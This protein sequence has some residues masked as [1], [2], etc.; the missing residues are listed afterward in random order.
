MDSQSASPD[1]SNVAAWSPEPK[2]N[3]VVGP[4]EMYEP[5]PRE[6]L[7]RNECIAFSPVD[8]KN[9]QFLLHPMPYPG[10]LGSS[11]AGTVEKVGRD[12]THFQPGD[13]VACNRASY[14]S[15]NLRFGAFQ[16]YAL[17][18]VDESS[19]LDP[20]TPIQAA[21]AVIVNLSVSV[22][23]L[24][25]YLKLSRPPLSGKAPSQGKKV[26]VYGGSS[27]CGGYGV[28][29]ASDAGYIV[30]TTSSPKHREFV[31][32]LGAAKIIDHTQSADKVVAELEANGPYEA[33]YDS[34]GLPAV[35]NILSGYLAER[36]GKY[37]TLLPLLGPENPVPSNVV[38]T[39]GAW[40][41]TLL[42][43]ANRDLG[44]WYYE[45]YVPQGLLS[46]AITPTR[47]IEVKGGL[48]KVQEAINMMGP[49]GVSGQ[50]LVLNPQE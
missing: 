10:I 7:V 38:R 28:K 41:A 13:K 34:I 9:Q 4:A 5:G 2:A 48:E 1:K 42:E 12:V 3:L 24:S 19:K 40:S 30:V 45:Q 35:T 33:I 27:S 17:A 15:G 29:Y 16:K 36:G 22:A 46:G 47:Q 26:L 31:S 20:Q 11:F 23:A 37:C 39:F 49:A 6:M 32:S 43:E 8:F 18:S 50:K 14:A 25:G 44:K 21:A